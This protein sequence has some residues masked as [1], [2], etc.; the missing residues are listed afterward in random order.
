MMYLLLGLLAALMGFT[1]LVMALKDG[2]A[3]DKSGRIAA[4][5]D[6]QPVAYWSYVLLFAL[7]ACVGTGLVL[8]SD[9]L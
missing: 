6:T 3:S 8:M 1:Y 2:F 7:L 5:R 9:H 4:R